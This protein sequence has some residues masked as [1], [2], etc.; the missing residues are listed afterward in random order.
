MTAYNDKYF[1]EMRR[2]PK[3]ENLPPFLI[4]YSPGKK[5]GSLLWQCSK[6]Q[7][8]PIIIQNVESLELIPVKRLLIVNKAK[9]LT[10]YSLSR[11]FFARGRGIGCRDPILHRFLPLRLFLRLFCGCFREAHHRREQDERTDN[12]DHQNR[13]LPR[14]HREQER[15]N[16]TASIL[17]RP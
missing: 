4:L 5:L 14:N 6:R 7:Q 15:G 3:G 2:Q 8:E 17:E 11:A 10:L 12:R 13:P 1:E 16:N 9:F